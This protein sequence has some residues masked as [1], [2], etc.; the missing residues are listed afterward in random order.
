MSAESK[1]NRDKEGF[2][3]CKD[4][5]RRFQTEI[6]FE[7]HSSFQ[8]KKDIATE[9]CQ[10]IE[11]DSSLQQSAVAKLFFGSQEDAKL[12]STEPQIITHQKCSE[13]KK[14]FSSDIYL[15]EH[16][17]NGLLM[18]SLKKCQECNRAI[19]SFI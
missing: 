2:M 16:L 8:H 19:T 17:Q 14:L 5:P 1:F 7:N 15:K 6:G 12:Q 4:C 10:T 18:S 3:K 11:D 13:C 9:L